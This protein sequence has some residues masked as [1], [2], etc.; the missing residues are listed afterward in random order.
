MGL[1]ANADREY[2]DEIAKRAGG[3]VLNLAGKTSLRQLMGLLKACRLLLTNDSGPMHVA[4]A[5]GTRVIVPFGSTS[6]EL[7]GPSQAGN[8]GHY[9]LR[10]DAV[11][12]P[13]FRRDC[14]I[15]F[16]CM[17]GITADQVLQAVLQVAEQGSRGY[18]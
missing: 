15:D 12:S 4:A 13:C 11:C 9:I 18:C 1:G 14:P 3:G 2:C 5:L 16:R 6:P 8:G 7:T 10:A 17:T